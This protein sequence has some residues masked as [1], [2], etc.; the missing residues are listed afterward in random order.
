MAG[1]VT[2]LHPIAMIGKTDRQGLESKYL[3]KLGNRKRRSLGWTESGVFLNLLWWRNPAATAT[4]RQARSG[5]VPYLE[6]L[7]TSPWN[8]FSCGKERHLLAGREGRG[9][10]AWLQG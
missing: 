2:D 8:A 4:L 7:G 5:R 1:A 3:E 10:G 6:F 9:A